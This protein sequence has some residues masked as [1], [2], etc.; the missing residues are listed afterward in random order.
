MLCLK[1]LGKP[2]GGVSAVWWS[3]QS[4]GPVYRG[5]LPGLSPRHWL[6]A[7]WVSYG[8]IIPQHHRLAKYLVAAVVRSLIS[9]GAVM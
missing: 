7:N 3:F 6:E 2:E 4:S 8:Q 1:K 9:I 5:E